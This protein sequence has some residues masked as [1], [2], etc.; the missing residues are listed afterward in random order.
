MRPSLRLL[1]GFALVLAVIGHCSTHAAET[2]PSAQVCAPVGPCGDVDSTGTVT[3]SDALKTLRKSVG[4]PEALTCE[5]SGT[6]TCPGAAPLKTGLKSCYDLNGVL[7]SCTGTGQ[8]GEFQVGVSRSFTDNGD[9][10]IT[11]NSTGLMWEKLG[12]DLGIHSQSVWYKWEEGFAKIITL[13]QSK[14]GGH[15]DWRMPNR[16]EMESL[17][18]LGEFSRSTTYAMVDPIFNTSC[19]QGCTPAHCSCTGGTYWTSSTDEQNKASAWG[20]NFGSGGVVD[21]YYK[22]FDAEEVRAVRTAR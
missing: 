1:T 9:G 8:D 17:Y 5:C 19:E 11:D 18:D 10:T 12:W 13:N 21:I 20:V 15:S 16:F 14:F 6:P 7:I 3:A 2:E 22:G 4:L